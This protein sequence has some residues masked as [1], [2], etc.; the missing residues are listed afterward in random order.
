ML[1]VPYVFKVCWGSRET[2]APSLWQGSG[3]SCWVSTGQLPLWSHPWEKPWVC[4]GTVS[5]SDKWTHVA[6]W[7]GQK[8]CFQSW[9]WHGTTWSSLVEFRRL[10]G[11]SM[12]GDD[13]KVTVRRHRDIDSTPGPARAM[14]LLCGGCQLPDPPFVFGIILSQQSNLSEP[15]FPYQYN[16][17]NNTCLGGFGEGLTRYCSGS[18]SHGSVAALSSP[19][20]RILINSD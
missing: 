10:P 8:I 3:S 5:G 2:M 16:R 13:N 15:Q 7:C 20:R 4:L 14:C 11:S 12:N 18:V 6:M 19:Y 1:W 9:Q 17:D